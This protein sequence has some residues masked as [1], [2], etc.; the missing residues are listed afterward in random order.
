MANNIE[1][2]V[3]RSDSGHDYVMGLNS[4]VATQLTGV[5]G[6][7]LV[8]AVPYDGTPELDGKPANMRPRQVLVVEPVTRYTRSIVCLTPTAPLW[9]GAASAITVED[10]DGV[11]HNCVVYNRIGERQRKRKP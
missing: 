6:D 3:Y 7:S 2:Y 10:S 11:A 4:E 8:G 1:P 9:T 5:G